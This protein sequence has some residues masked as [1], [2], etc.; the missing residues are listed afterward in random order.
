MESNIIDASDFTGGQ[1]GQH[2]LSYDLL[3]EEQPQNSSP[4]SV[5]AG[6]GSN[7]GAISRKEL[8]ELQDKW[9]QKIAVAQE[10]AYQKGWE[11][12]QQA[13]REE[14]LSSMEQHL[15]PLQ[16]AMGAMDQE[17]NSLIEE[18]KPY[19]ATM[20][21]DIAEKILDIPLDDKELREKVS[22]EIRNTLSAIDREIMIK[23]TVSEKDY[24]YVVRKMKDVP[25][26]NYLQISGSDKLKTGEYTIDTEKES[27]VKNF[28]KMLRD[29]RE[30][31]AL[32]KDDLSIDSRDC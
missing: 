26:S 27:I 10:E 9:K 11:E 12:G 1:H 20:T 16:E 14:A 3:F 8:Q 29:F 22:A 32:E 19:M 30:K 17:I 13:G 18:L 15:A 24:G 5:R 2:R 25:H 7:D 21:F 6:T 31:V 28:K 23:I 4:D